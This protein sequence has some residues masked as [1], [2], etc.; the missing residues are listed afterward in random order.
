MESPLTIDEFK[1]A[2][3]DI[4]SRGKKV[5]TGMPYVKEVSPGL[6]EINSGSGIM[7]TGDE[8][9]KQFDEA[10]KKYNTNGTTIH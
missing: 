2:M 4:M 6:W 5:S 1:K 9:K 7:W 8:G 10:M 3:D